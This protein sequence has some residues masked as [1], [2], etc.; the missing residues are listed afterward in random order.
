MATQNAEP[1]IRGDLPP[2]VVEDILS[3]EDRR[4]ALAAL[5]AADEPIVVEDLAAIIVGERE[6]CPPS[7][8]SATDRAAMTEELF[9]EHI[10]KLMETAVVEYDSMLGAVELRQRDIASQRR[11]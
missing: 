8:V 1:D 2:A 5:A 6:D 3:D 7:A 9:T 10:P 4:R 11:A